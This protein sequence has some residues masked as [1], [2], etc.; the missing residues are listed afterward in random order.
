MPTLQENRREEIS[1]TVSSVEAEQRQRHRMLLALLVLF[2]ALILVLVKD[3]EFWFPGSSAEPEV[4]EPVAPATSVA[5]KTPIVAI[6]EKP[7]PPV[8]ARIHQRSRRAAAKAP[9]EPPAQEVAAAAPPVVAATNRAV[10]PPLEVEVVAGDQHQTLNAGNNS[11]NVEL[12]SGS[13]AFG[14]QPAPAPAQD[15]TAQSSDQRV[16]LS[17]GTAQV[18]SRPVSPNY[19]LLAKQMKVQGAVVLQALIDRNGSIQDI[20]VLSGPT[21]LSAAAR[22]AVRQWRFK[23]YYQ[24]GHAVETEARITVNFTIS[25]Y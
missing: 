4:A 10:L 2:V 21:I 14:R 23:P 12:H 7:A 20:Q 9:A 18:L 15:N 3:R 5:P 8:P 19:P 22:E 11:V 17:P 13:A 1:T 24:S 6:P 16:Q 25:T